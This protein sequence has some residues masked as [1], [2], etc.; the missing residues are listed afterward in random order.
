MTFLFR[1]R[2]L[3]CGFINSKG[4]RAMNKRLSA[5]NRNWSKLCPQGAAIFQA[6]SDMPEKPGFLNVINH[7]QANNNR[8]NLRTYDS[9]ALIFYGWA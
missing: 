7:R 2:G 6:L 8:F 5:S 9:V 3:V 1:F 4:V